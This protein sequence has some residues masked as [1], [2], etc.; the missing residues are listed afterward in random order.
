MKKLKKLFFKLNILLCASAVLVLFNA[1]HGM[2]NRRNE[3]IE[4]EQKRVEIL[5]RIE[6]SNKFLE[7]VHRKS[8]LIV[9]TKEFEDQK[10]VSNYFKSNMLN[11]LHKSKLKGVIESIYGNEVKAQ[12]HYIADY[13]INLKNVSIKADDEGVVHIQ[14]NPEDLILSLKQEVPK[15]V[16]VGG[17]GCFPADFGEENMILF[18]SESEKIAFE[19][20]KNDNEFLDVAMESARENLKQIADN[21]GASIVF[22]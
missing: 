11:K 3:S 13:K 2:N 16:Y 19:D 6:K 8:E 1:V 21:C 9:A 17:N 7:E 10:S 12:I 5:S 18:L 14:I 22:E 4:M 15:D 20:V